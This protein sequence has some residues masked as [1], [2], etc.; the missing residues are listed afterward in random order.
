MNQTEFQNLYRVFTPTERTAEFAKS[1][2]SWNDQVAKWDSYYQ[3]IK[4]ENGLPL[5]RWLK[6]AEGYLPDFLEKKEENFGHARPGNMSQNMI[7]YFE[8]LNGNES[9]K[10]FKNTYYNGYENTDKYKEDRTN[11]QDVENAYKQ[12]IL[13]LLKKLVEAGSLEEIY[14]LESDP[15][16]VKYEAKQILRKISILMSV[17]DDCPYKNGFMW[18]FGE[19]DV[20]TIAKLL[21]VDYDD[22]KTFLENNHIVF[23]KAKEYAGI[24]ETSSHDDYINLYDFIWSLTD[25]TFNTAEFSD[26][27]SINVIFNGAPGTG[28]TYGVTRGIKKLQNLDSNHFKKSKFIQ[29]HPSFTYQ[30]FIEGIKPLGVVGGNLDLEVVNGCFKDFC[31]FVKEQ[32]EA[33]Y[34]GLDKKPNPEKPSDFIDWPHYYFI[35]DEINRGNL[36]NIFGETFTLLEKDYRDY[37]FSGNYTEKG[38]SLVSTALSSVINRLDNPAL[39]YKKVEGEVCFGIPFNIH[40]IG[41]MNDVDKSIDAFDL[42]LRRRFRGIPK[43]C[44]YDVIRDSLVELGYPDENVDDYV[45]ACKSLNNFICNPTGDGLRLGRSY[46]IGHAFFLKVKYVQGNKKITASKKKEVF[47]NYI[48][49]TLKE[50]IRQVADE[51]DIDNLID[52]ASASFGIK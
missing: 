17:M 39:I 48:L 11:P 33:F 15:D 25:K 28:K 44:N 7:F 6:N 50:Y 35:V 34:N 27:N 46:E 37:D 31:I 43:Y 22:K 19:D 14:E 51:S 36:S 40:F 9:L 1:G 5:N 42:A 16:Y 18:I 21:E 10:K 4:S 20:N 8:N 52:K 24:T 32:N 49:G 3:D 29:F 26:F 12:H 47:E 45:E 41:M 13:P 30:D 23:E 38:P 2:Q